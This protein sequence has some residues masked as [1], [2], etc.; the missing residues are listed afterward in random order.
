MGVCKDPHEDPCWA[1]ALGK[2]WKDSWR[3]PAQLTLSNVPVAS[4]RSCHLSGFSWG[5]LLLYQ[6]SRGLE[7]GVLGRDCAGEQ[8]LSHDLPSPAL[9][10]PE[11]GRPRTARHTFN[12]GTAL[13]LSVQTQ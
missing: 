11:A 8:V 6:S 1:P 2:L 13:Q 12:L 7:G 3:S 9:G 10:C 4:A 5:N